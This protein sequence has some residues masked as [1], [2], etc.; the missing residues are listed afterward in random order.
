M[1]VIYRPCTREFPGLWVT[2][3]HVAAPVGKPTRFVM[4]HDS[5]PELRSILPPGLHCFPRDPSDAP[6]VQET[7]L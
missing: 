7:W 4:T 3:M 1:W 6:E 5:L 2:R